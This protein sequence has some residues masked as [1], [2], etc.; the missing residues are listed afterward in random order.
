VN[1]GSFTVRG[2]RLAYRSFGDAADFPVL[3]LHGFFDHGLSFAPLIRR[4]GAP[5]F[6]VAPDHR[7][8]G[9]SDWIGAGGYYHFPDYWQDLL[10]LIEHLRLDRFGIVGHSMGGG[11]ATGVAALIPE[12]VKAM[13]L[14]EGMGPPYHDAADAIGRLDRWIDGTKKPDMDRDVAGRRAARAVIPSV[15]DA[16]DR[17]IRANPRLSREIATELAGTFTEPLANGVAWKVDPLHRTQAPKAFLQAEIE[18]MWRALSMPVM[19]VYGSESPWVPED[20]DFRHSCLL[21][22]HVVQIEGAGHNLHHERPEQI[23]DLVT[24]WMTT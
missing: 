4:L 12:R 24:R 20:L 15:N 5:F 21:N 18:P 17:L 1:V 3:M 7:G 13:V 14:L 19:S 9:D 2:L 11:I 22:G 10:R 6:V 23:A 8:F 16:I